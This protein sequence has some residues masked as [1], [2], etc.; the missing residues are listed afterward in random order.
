MVNHEDDERGAC[1]HERNGLG[2]EGDAVTALDLLGNPVDEHARDKHQDNVDV[3]PGDCA[4][5]IPFPGGTHLLHHVLGRIPGDFVGFGGVEVRTGAEEQAR[6]R[7][8]DERERHVPG[9]VNAVDVLVAKQAEN[10]HGIDAGKQNAK[11]CRG[12]RENGDVG[13]LKDNGARGEQNERSK[14]L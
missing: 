13:L 11:V 1:D 7:D 5:G 8:E 9:H 10:Q 6:E 2:G 4:D 14:N 3:F 12:D